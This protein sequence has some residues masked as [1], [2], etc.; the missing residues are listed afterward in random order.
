MDTQMTFPSCTHNWPATGVTIW[1]LMRG[2]CTH[3]RRGQSAMLRLLL[4]ND[5]PAVGNARLDHSPCGM[6]TKTTGV[7]STIRKRYG[8]PCSC[9]RNTDGCGRK[10]A[11]FRSVCEEGH[12]K[13]IESTREYGGTMLATRR[14]RD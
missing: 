1:S 11:T 13:C 14:W 5:W 4:V 8:Q 6:S 2:G 7:R 9:S 12:A 3:H 10:M